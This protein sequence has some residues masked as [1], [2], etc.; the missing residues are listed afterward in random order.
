MFLFRQAKQEW[1]T[2]VTGCVVFFPV[3]AAKESVPGMVRAG[4]GLVEVPRQLAQCFRLPLG[5]VEMIFSPLPEVDFMEGLRDTGKG[6]IA[7]FKFCM[8]TLEMPYEVYS[9]LSDAATG[10]VE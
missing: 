4:R 9:G 2:G 3:I 7:P 10:V 8:A 5:L 1:R 6:V